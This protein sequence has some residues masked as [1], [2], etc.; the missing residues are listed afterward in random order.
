MTINL[1][2]TGKKRVVR[3]G[4]NFKISSQIQLGRKLGRWKE[5]G[6]NHQKIFPKKGWQ[7]N[8]MGVNR[9]SLFLTLRL[10]LPWLTKKGE[11]PQGIKI[12]GKET[13]DL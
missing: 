5:S 2:I 1:L 13:Q 9:D 12:G 4:R 3:R 11:Q 8:G 10:E 6:L 7:F